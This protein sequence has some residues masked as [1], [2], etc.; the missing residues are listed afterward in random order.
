MRYL[1]T[2]SQFILWRIVFPNDSG[3]ELTT[4]RNESATLLHWWLAVMLVNQANII[5]IS[6]IST[7]KLN[8]RAA[9]LLAVDF[10]QS[11]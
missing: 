9:P 10:L 7:D 5:S 3:N 11:A 8:Q 1:P 4:H 6:C 2:P